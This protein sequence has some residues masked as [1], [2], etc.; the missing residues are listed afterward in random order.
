MTAE[1]SDMIEMPQTPEGRRA[2]AIKRIKAK[3]DF[4]IHL[5][6]YLI[7]N[8][9]LVVIWAFTTA[10]QPFPQG[11]FWPIFV[12]AGWGIGV[13]IN[14]YVAYRGNV[15]TEAQIQQEMKHLPS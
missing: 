14:G 10:G 11:F 12:I 2:L 8:A 15:Y 4:K 9:M 5:A 13:V 6:V 3:N 7:V 1:T